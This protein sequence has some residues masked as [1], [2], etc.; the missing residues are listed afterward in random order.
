MEGFTGG[1]MERT[2]LGFIA[3]ERLGISPKTLASW[4]KAGKIKASRTASN[5]RLYSAADIEKLRK[6]RIG[7]N[8]HGA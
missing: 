2:M 5:W 8:G 7:R 4:E 6:A 1:H 3:A